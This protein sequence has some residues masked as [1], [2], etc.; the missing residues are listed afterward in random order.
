MI[1]VPLHNAQE[2]LQDRQKQGMLVDL[3]VFGLVELARKKL[4]K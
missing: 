4:E 2:F 1:E 3:K